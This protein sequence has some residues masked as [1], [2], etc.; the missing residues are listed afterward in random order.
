MAFSLSTESLAAASARRP[1]LVIGAWAALFVVA[2]FLIVTL[3][4]G[5]AEAS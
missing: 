5:A 3:L 1:W 4:A 2:V